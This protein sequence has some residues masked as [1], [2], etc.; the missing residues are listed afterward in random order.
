MVKYVEIIKK[1][2]VNPLHSSSKVRYVQEVETNGGEQNERKTSKYPL[3]DKAV[4]AIRNVPWGRIVGVAS[5]KSKQMGSIAFKEMKQVKV[6]NPVK[7]V[8][9]KLFLMFFVSIL[10]FVLIVGMISYTVSKNV[11]K[12]KVSES[13]LQ[14]VTQAG[15]KLDFLYQTFD[16]VSLTNYA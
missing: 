12:N 5:K 11:I 10:F 9:M 3:L 4:Q 8:G 16:E 14:T 1:R 6:E 15:Q 7:S 2:K 13:S